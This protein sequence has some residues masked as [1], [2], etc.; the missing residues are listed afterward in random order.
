MSD[1]R[2]TDP[3]STRRRV[4]KTDLDV[5]ALGLG[6]NVFGSSVDESTGFQMLDAYFDAGGNLIDTADSYCAFMGTDGGESETIIGNW[7]RSRGCRDQMV[8]ATKVGQAPNRT[9]LRPDTIR[10]AI[11]GS[12]RRLGT[13]YVDLYY[14]HEDH[15]DPLDATIETFDELQRA[16]K[17][18]YVAA[19][20]YS[21]ARLTAALAESARSARASYVALQPLYNL[22]DRADYEADL[23]PVVA[24]HGLGVFPYF[25]LASGYLTGKYRAGQPAVDSLRIPYVEPYRTEHNERVVDVV[26]DVAAE[27]G[28]A[29]AA[30]ALAWLAGRPGV[31]APL[32]SASSVEQLQDLLGFVGLRLSHTHRVALDSVSAPAVGASL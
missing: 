19:S 9:N 21:G 2:V 15:G 32:A 30:I 23:A 10:A 13:D 11:D 4:P 26:C 14:A 8:I 18:R 17:I 5:F 1:N 24:Q 22:L 6:G 3:A 29:P 20:N 12:L 27:C 31:I 25:S 28:V 7:M 16:G